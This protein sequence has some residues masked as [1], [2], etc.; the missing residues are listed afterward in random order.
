MVG[1]SRLVLGVVVSLIAISNADAFGGRFG[2]WRSPPAVSYYYA[3]PYPMWCP[4][5][6][7]MVVPVPDA[8][9]RWANPV[10]A[11]PSQSPEPPLQKPMKLTGDPRMPVITA[12]HALGGNYVP[13]KAPAGDRCR[14]GFWN[15]TGRDVT[16]HVEGKAVTVAKDKAVTVELDRQFTWQIAGQTQHIERVPDG[17]ASHDVIMRE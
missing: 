7:P 3:V 11:P 16:I 14:V 10:A 9:P 1:S 15:L 2:W 17:Q 4:P 12:S 8:A 5:A 6:V 13:G